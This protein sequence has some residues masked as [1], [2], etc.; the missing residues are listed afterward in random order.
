[1]MPKINRK[2][3]SQISF[4]FMPEFRWPHRHLLKN[5]G[6]LRLLLLSPLLWAGL[7][8]KDVSNIREAVGISSRNL[9]KDIKK[10]DWSAVKRKV[11][12]LLTVL[13]FLIFAVL[14]SLTFL[15]G[16][17]LSVAQAQDISEAFALPGQAKDLVDQ[18]FGT[19]NL[20]PAGNVFQGALG[21]MLFWYN[22]GFSVLAAAI[23]IYKGLFILVETADDKY[24]NLGGSS[25]NFTW[26]V[27]RSVLAMALMVPLF[28]GF[29]GGQLSVISIANTGSSLSTNVWDEFASSSISLG[30]PVSTPPVPKSLEDT[31]ARFI[32]AE[33]C[34]IAA[35]TLANRAGDQPYIILEQTSISHDTIPPSTQVVVNY[36]GRPGVVGKLACGQVRFPSTGVSDT[37]LYNELNSAPAKHIIEAQKQAFLQTRPAVLALADELAAHFVPGTTKYGLPLPDP[38]ALLAERGIL[39]TWHQ[40]ILSA[41][42][43][44]RKISDQNFSKKISEQIENNGWVSAGAWFHNIAT[45]NGQFIDAAAA[46]PTISSPK[47]E[48]DQKLP[49]VGNVVDGLS[50]W[51]AE[52]HDRNTLISTLQKTSKTVTGSNGVGIW[53]LLN[54]YFD[55][56][57]VLLSF[58]T[59]DS[60][61]P[62]SDLANLGHTLIDMATAGFAA[63]AVA[64]AV[65]LV[66]G[67]IFSFIGYALIMVLVPG[68]L[69]AVW[70]P[71]LPFIRFI[72][73]ILGWLMDL[74][75]AVVFVPLFLMAH[76]STK[77]EGL[78]TSITQPGYNMLLQLFLRPVLM[79]IGLIAGL[80]I[81]TTIIKLF[82]GY[83]YPTIIASNGGSGPVIL[84]G[85]IIFYC[86]SAY[87]L[88]NTSFK[89]I[90]ILPEK[91][92]R[93]IGGVSS[94]NTEDTGTAERQFSGG[95]SKGEGLSARLPA[96]KSVPGK[97]KSK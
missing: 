15:S 54:E 33:A 85:Y 82:N 52:H 3:K 97:G 24:G 17:L 6:T 63:L 29:N 78:Y 47:E 81:F 25:N 30:S 39:T 28:G 42:Q 9:L 51:W 23:L 64:S 43:N 95:S 67:T 53:D 79:V 41:I 77:E 20:G 60:S 55:I 65:P 72:F 73:G 34:T 36:N 94:V 96:S 8:T 32:I 26:F 7:I 46:L 48:I 89:A 80:L 45:A 12:A 21:T 5:L 37:G 62:L 75:E 74:L 11:P 91:A 18:I 56:N 83:L 59:A 70:L 88:A 40:N 87:G 1:M 57:Q 31:L 71:M 22:I 86:V 66:N 19:N 35:N 14:S 68:F 27:I 38:E 16:L 69:L 4:I 13:G 10:E 50:H 84:I 92:L 44:A 76:I 58:A 90:D 49:I 61:M 2:T 93:W